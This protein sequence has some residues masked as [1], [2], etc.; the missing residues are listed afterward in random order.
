MKPTDR[1][2]R[3]MFVANFLSVSCAGGAGGGGGGDDG[4][5][6]SCLMC[7]CGMYSVVRR[8]D[9]AWHPTPPYTN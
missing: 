6:V 5:D 7:V 4:G 2:C 8:M 3:P 1:G 9:Y